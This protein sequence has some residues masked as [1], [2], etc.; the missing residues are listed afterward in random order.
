MNNGPAVQAPAISEE[1]DLIG[2]VV[3][4]ATANPIARANAVC[5]S[6]DDL[7][8]AVA[9]IQKLPLETC[10]REARTRCL[11][12]MFK[13][14]DKVI[15]VNSR[16]EAMAQVVRSGKIRRWVLPNIV[17]EIVFLAATKEPILFVEEEPSFDA[18]SFVSFVLANAA[19]DGHA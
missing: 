2:N 13:Q 18:A 16:L 9:E 6:V 4:Q 19:V 7:I 8:I 3:D 1:E 11:A 14:N 17:A 10:D 15:A 12:R 5:V